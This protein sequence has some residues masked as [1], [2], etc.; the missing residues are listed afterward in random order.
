MNALL[1]NFKGKLWIFY[2]P[3]RWGLFEDFKKSNPNRT[4]VI[5]DDDGKVES[6]FLNELELYSRF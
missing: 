4:V 3:V 1:V 6:A 5:E 2:S